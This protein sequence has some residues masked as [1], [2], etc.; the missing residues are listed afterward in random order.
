MSKTP[1][2][3]GKPIGLKSKDTW[4]ILTALKF[5]KPQLID[6]AQNKIIPQENCK[7]S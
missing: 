2:D 1:G 5:S 4:E 7:E 3:I 6:M